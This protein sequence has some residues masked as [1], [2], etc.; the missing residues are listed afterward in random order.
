MES[1][2]VSVGEVA[3]A[4]GCSKATVSLVLRNHP[5]PSKV[6]RE[7]VLK[8]AE[9]LGYVPDALVASAMATVSQ[10]KSKA[11]LPIAWVNTDWREDSWEVY[12]FHSPYLKG[13]RDGALKLGYRIEPIWAG[14]PGLKMK[15]LAQ[16][17]DQ[18]GIQGAIITKPARRIHL[19]WSRLASVSLEGSVLAPRLHRILTN[20]YHNIYVAL[21]MLRRSGYRRIGVFLDGLLG[22][23]YP[24]CIA[25]A[26]YFHAHIPPSDVIPPFLYPSGR[27][28]ELDK[29]R[30]LLLPYVAKH[31]PDVIVV[32]D[33][34]LEEV[35]LA[36]GYRVPEEIGIVHL[37]TDDDAK[38]WAGISS[39]KR[40]IGLMAVRQVVSMIQQGQFG[41]PDIA[42]DI[43]IKGIWHSGRTLLA[44]KPITAKGK[45]RVRPVV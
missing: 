19:E 30:D 24:P 6:T 41:L 43:S 39:R 9:M 22:R 25:A 4:V 42:A 38:D 33:F 11:L 7:R 8:A 10:A 20:Y 28:R 21:K 23:A 16:I 14:E 2:S 1:H 36:A 35:L 5:G 45:V 17:V 3:K 26:D 31:K 12:P 40:E 34:R 44:S 29:L 37:A 18:R 13:A 27:N 32:H 15:R